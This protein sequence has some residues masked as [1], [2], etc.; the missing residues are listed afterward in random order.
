MNKKAGKETNTLSFTRIRATTPKS[1]NIANPP[2]ET[3]R[4]GVEIN[5]TSSPTAPTIS[6][7]A[8]STPNFSSPNRSNSFFM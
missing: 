5:P 3:K 1:I 8:V 7:I 4:M 2:E 6:R